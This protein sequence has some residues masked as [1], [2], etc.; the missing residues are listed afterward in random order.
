MKVSVFAG[1]I[2][3]APADAICTSTNPRLSLMMGTGGSVRERGGFAILRECEAL[4]EAEA[5]RS[6]RDRLPVGSVW[7]TG[8]GALPHQAVFHCVASDARARSSDAVIRSCVQKSVAAAIQ[9]GIT[10]VAMPVFATG[11]AHVPFDSALA[12]IAEG[13]A[14]APEGL[15]EV[16]IVV[17]DAA[18]AAS[19]VK[20]LRERFP[21]AARR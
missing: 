1:D 4:L 15:G 17:R 10:S 12:S 14:S 8:A 18:A 16:I 2:A 3:E 11:H 20:I 9:R 21:E 7:V 13:L 5:T 6:G 19:A